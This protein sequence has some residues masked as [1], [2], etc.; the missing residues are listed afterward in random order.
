MNIQK[1]KI[2]IFLTLENK[3]IILFLYNHDY[4]IVIIVNVKQVRPLK[5]WKKI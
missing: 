2:Q 1:T 5:E 4:I 3:I